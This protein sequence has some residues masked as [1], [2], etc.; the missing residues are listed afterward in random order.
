M[1]S[2]GTD[3]QTITISPISWVYLAIVVVAVGLLW[4]LSGVVILVLASIIFAAAL[5]PS[6]VSLQ[7]MK[8]PRP[9]AV[10]IL[11]IVFFGVLGIVLYLVTPTI[12]QQIQ[13][14]VN[15]L[16]STQSRVQASLASQPWLLAGYQKLSATVASRP[17]LVINQV[18]Q[19]A[20]GVVAS[21]FGFVTVLV[22]TFYF[23]LNGRQIAQ[24]LV[25]Y[26]P[27]RRKRDEVLEIGLNSSV[28]LGHWI[29]GQL[30]L[31]LI[32]FVTTFIA[33]SLLGVPYA[34]T[35]ALFA[36]LLQFIPFVGAVVGAIPAVL[37]AFTISPLKALFVVIF[38]VILQTLLGNIIGPQVMKKAVGV[39]P[40]IIL[41]AA[42]V[43]YTLLGVVGVILA[44]PIAAVIDVVYES[45]GSDFV[46]E[47]INE[48]TQD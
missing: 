42:L 20:F 41:I 32:V 25:K 3:R 29:R 17:D 4:Y 31:C 28:K 35:L 43:G 14:L 19:T 8:I 45:Q 40:I 10:A 18:S 27:T 9:L 1:A 44:V 24:G 36:G 2:R 34:L 13:S 12:T 22:L 30:L 38:F 23:L 11:Y 7:K 15:N 16:P 21:V 48:A 26:V 39:S 5:N 47:K 46:K 6:V 37:V 33:L